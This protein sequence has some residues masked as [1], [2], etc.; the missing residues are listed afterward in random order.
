MP[1]SKVDDI[2]GSIVFLYVWLRTSI[3]DF[4]ILDNLWY[5]LM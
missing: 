1:R 4:V 3:L 5:G 2:V